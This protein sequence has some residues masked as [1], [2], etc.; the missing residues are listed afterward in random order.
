VSQWVT[1]TCDNCQVVITDA[2]VNAVKVR[3]I[4]PN[5]QNEH[6]KDLCSSCAVSISITVRGGHVMALPAWAKKDAER[7]EGGSFLVGVGSRLYAVHSDYQ[8][9]YTADNY[10]A[11][12]SGYLA[13]LGS[14]HT[15]KRLPYLD[16]EN[17]VAAAL[18]AASHVTSYVRP[19]FTLLA[20]EPSVT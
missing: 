20:T 2:D 17:R 4:N 15:T 6:E 8:I 5:Y 10:M 13:A 3:L 18:S 19:P 14:L 11:V 9:A 7:E 1:D 12:G 16:S